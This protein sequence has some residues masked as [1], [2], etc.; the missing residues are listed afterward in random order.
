MP[1]ALLIPIPIHV[2]SIPN[3][4]NTLPLEPCL[5]KDGNWFGDKRSVLNVAKR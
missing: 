3:S 4:G 5:L 2:L 1:I